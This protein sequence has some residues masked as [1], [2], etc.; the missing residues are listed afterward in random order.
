MHG[1]RDNE[2]LLQGGYDVIIISPLGGASGEFL[3]V[4]WKSGHDFLIG[5]YGI[6]LSGMHGFRNNEV[7]LQ[8]RYDV[9][10]ISP[11][12]GASGEFSWRILIERPLFLDSISQ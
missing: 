5:F 3:W 6:F 8:T 9:I 10:M 2:V 7:L 1:F 11:L 4:F 12:E